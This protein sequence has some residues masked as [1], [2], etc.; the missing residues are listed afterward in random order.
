M[1]KKRRKGGRVALS[2]SSSSE[3]LKQHEKGKGKRGDRVGWPPRSS[4][5]GERNKRVEELDRPVEKGGKSPKERER[6]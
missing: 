5:R 6:E 2:S 4:R 3:Q 1:Q